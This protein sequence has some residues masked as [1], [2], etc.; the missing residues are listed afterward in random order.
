MTSAGLNPF[1]E[2]VLGQALGVHRLLLRPAGIVKPERWRYG[3]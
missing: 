1:W 2:I 3:V